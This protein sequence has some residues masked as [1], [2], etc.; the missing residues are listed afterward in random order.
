MPSKQELPE[1]LQNLR[2]KGDGFISPESDYFA[3]LAEKAAARAKEPAKITRTRPNRWWLSAAAIAL[4]ALF[5]W[6]ALDHGDAPGDVPELVSDQPTSEE[7][8]AEISPEAIEAYI[9][10]ELDQFAAELYYTEEI[11]D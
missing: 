7:L 3:R 2:E 1:L 10:E 11:N 9:G 8:L 6:L 4:L 5:T